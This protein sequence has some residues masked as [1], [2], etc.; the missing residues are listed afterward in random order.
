MSNKTNPLKHILLADDGTEN[1]VS[2]IKFLADLPRG[3]DCTVT[4]IRV[5]TPT[6]GS[7]YSRI[8]EEMSVTRNFLKSRHFHF[9]AEAKLGDPVK[10]IIHRAETLQPDL[11]VLGSKATGKL[12]GLLGNVATEVT[13]AGKWP[14][15]IVKKQFQQLRKVLLAVDGSE[16]SQHT[17]DFLNTFPLNEPCCLTV[18]HVVQPVQVT[19]PIEPAGMALAAI[20]PAEEERINNENLAT[21]RE[22]VNKIS[23]TLTSFAEIDHVVV[24]GDVVEEILALLKKG[25]YDLLVIG[26]RGHGNLSGW[27]LGSISRSLVQSAP[28]SILVFRS[29]T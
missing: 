24:L 22:M 11:V 19:Y 27:L 1:M 21:G 10:E 7:E 4:A 13:H 3:D 26:S 28:S 25:E 23:A 2:A 5:F 9:S 12:G 17:A 6:E 15:L 20:S 16:F 18:T 8:E 29:G 14:V